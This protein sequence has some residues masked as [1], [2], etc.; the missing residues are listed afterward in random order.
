MIAPFLKEKFGWI[1][2]DSCWW[3]SGGRQS[4]EHH[5]KEGRIWK[6]EIRLLWKTVGDISGALK[7]RIEGVHK[8]RKGFRLGT[9]EG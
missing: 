8:R 4:R 2:S 7:D 3:C 5:F 1:E 6:E 9:S